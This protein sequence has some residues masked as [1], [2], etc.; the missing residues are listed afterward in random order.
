[1]L[2]PPPA[3]VNPK[4]RRLYYWLWFSRRWHFVASACCSLT[5]FWARHRSGLWVLFSTAIWAM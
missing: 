4:G 3:N 5:I 2:T 1:M